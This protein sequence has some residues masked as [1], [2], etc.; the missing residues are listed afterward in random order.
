MGLAIGGQ[1]ARITFQAVRAR[2]LDLKDEYRESDLESA[3]IS[4]LLLELGGDFTSVG[5]QR[6]LRVGNASYKI[7]LRFFHRRQRSS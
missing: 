3:L 6:R 2:V 7:D 4:T 1:R 5:P